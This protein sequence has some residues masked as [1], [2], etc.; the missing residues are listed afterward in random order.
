VKLTVY[1]SRE[2]VKEA[3]SYTTTVPCAFML[4][5]LIT[6][7]KN[8]VFGLSCILVTRHEFISNFVCTYF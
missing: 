2:E 6:H 8:R 5:C 7:R 3:W 1:T 4:W